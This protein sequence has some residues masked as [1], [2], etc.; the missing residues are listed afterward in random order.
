MALIKFLIEKIA[1]ICLSISNVFSVFSIKLI[2]KFQINVYKPKYETEI[3]QNTEEI[4]EDTKNILKNEIEI[5]K[6]KDREKIIKELINR[7]IININ[8][9]NK[10]SNS[11]HFIIIPRIY[12]TINDKKVRKI[13]FKDNGSFKNSVF[14]YFDKEQFVNLGKKFSPIYLKDKYDIRKPYR[15]IFVFKKLLDDKLKELIKEDN[16]EIIKLIQRHKR[17]KEIKDFFGED[18]IS[19]KK[20]IFLDYMVI[21]SLNLNKENITVER[22]TQK[23]FIFKILLNE[24]QNVKIKEIILDSGLKLFLNEDY[25]KHIQEKLLKNESNIKQKLNIKNFFD[26]INKSDFESVLKD[27]LLENYNQIYIDNFFK[28]QKLIKEI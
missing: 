1:N 24:A 25:P 18:D 19:N 17:R 28:I 20:F 5:K 6:Y 13:L 4:K 14:R 15:D 9:L 21:S 10:V 22:E 7:E 3:L 12:L 27:I 26:D 8:N 16:K 2:D 11:E 23:R